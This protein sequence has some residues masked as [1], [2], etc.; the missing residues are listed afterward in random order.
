MVF[1]YGSRRE[2]RGADAALAGGWCR[3]RIL[4]TVLRA[5][6]SWRAIW[7]TETPSTKPRRSTS[8]TLPD[9]STSFI[10]SR[11]IVDHVDVSFV[12]IEAWAPGRVVPTQDLAY[13]PARHVEV[14][15]D[16]AHGEALDQAESPHLGDV[17]ERVN[18]LHLA[19]TRRR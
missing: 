15:G 14:A 4:R 8:A 19:H 18:G 13:G 6:L 11:R 10:S 16:P 3:P 1:S 5:I 7:R 9:G 2:P 17:A 12:Q